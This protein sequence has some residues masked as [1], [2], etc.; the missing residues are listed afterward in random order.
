M[1][2][3]MNEEVLFYT[4]QALVEAPKGI[5]AMDESVPTIT[6]RFQ[7]I[8]LDATPH[9]RKQYRD[10]LLTCPLLHQYI[11]GVI[12]HEETLYDLAGYLTPHPDVVHLG[13]LIPGIKV[14]Q[15]TIELPEYP[16][17]RVTEGIDSLAQRVKI[18]HGLGARFAKWRAV[19]AIGPDFPSHCCIEAN[20]SLLARYAVICQEQGLVPIVEPEILMEG[21]HSLADCE[22]ATTR[23]LT[24]LF[25]ELLDQRAYM[26]GLLLKINMVTAGTN[27]PKCSTDAEIAT[28]SYRT[29]KRTVPIDVPGVVFLSGGQSTEQ[30]MSR[31]NAIN[32]AAG[33][34]P[35]WALSF[36][37]G[38]ALQH[39]TMHAWAGEL[40]NVED[41][42]LALFRNARAASFATVGNLKQEH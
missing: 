20:T 7:A 8:N 10:L 42:Q 27:C 26:K 22:T 37:F 35:P 38:R 41:A 19:F 3:S 12:L 2:D 33:D 24:A 5:L 15:G 28:A 36:S 17:E 31:L 21:A 16:G 4:A 39:D 13:K 23:V 32:G 1:A 11:S 30:S 25:E 9:R 29:L 18:Y 6:K 14:D 34:A 40:H